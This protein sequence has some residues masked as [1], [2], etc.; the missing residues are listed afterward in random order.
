MQNVIPRLTDTPG[1]IE[2]PGAE[3]GEHNEE[4]YVGELGVSSEE[5]A[6]LRESGVV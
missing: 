2:H 6:E 4:V 1:R 5:L 3:L